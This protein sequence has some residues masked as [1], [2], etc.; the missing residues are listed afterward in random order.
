MATGGLTVYVAGAN[1]TVIP[2][3]VAPGTAGT[4]IR[5]AGLLAQAR[6]AAVASTS[7]GRILYVASQ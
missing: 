6:P 4:P 2:V 1:S 7:D 5:T 3:D